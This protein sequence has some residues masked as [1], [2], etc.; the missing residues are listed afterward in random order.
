MNKIPIVVCT[1]GSPCVEVLKLS[2]KVYAPDHELI[3][4]EGERSTFGEAYNKALEEA[5]RKYDE[6]IVANDDIVLTPTSMQLMIEDVDRLKEV[7]KPKELGF[8]GALHDSARPS[9][10]IR[11][12]FFEDDVITFGKWKSEHVIKQSPVI[13][14]IFSYFSKAAFEDVQFPPISWYSDDIICE[15]LNAL[16]YK[17]FIS[18]SYVHHVGSYTMGTNY[19]AA[20]EEAMPWIREN[21]PQ[22]LEEL[23]RRL[24]FG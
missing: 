20:R 7:F 22:H 16:G 8:V 15:D 6:V 5:F 10:N 11:Y 9:Q 18:R 14:P 4:H 21:R 17:H 19:N 3:V 23:N 2:A 12:N 24:S 13:A 1:I